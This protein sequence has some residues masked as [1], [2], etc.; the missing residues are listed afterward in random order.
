M[1]ADLADQRGESPGCELGPHI[2]VRSEEGGACTM[3]EA[4][5]AAAEAGEGSIQVGWTPLRTTTS[6]EPTLDE[7]R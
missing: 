2:A 4:G 3:P 6:L 5:E 7:C 1:R